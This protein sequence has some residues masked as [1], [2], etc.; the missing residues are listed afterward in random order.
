M[1]SRGTKKIFP[2][3]FGNEEICLV[4]KAEACLVARAAVSMAHLGGKGQGLE[5]PVDSI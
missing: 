2:L 3:C 1:I 4:A 5:L